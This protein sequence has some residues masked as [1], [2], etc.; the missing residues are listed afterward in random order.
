MRGLCVPKT[1]STSCDQAIFID[2]ATDA[3]VTSDAVLLKIDRFGQWCQQRGAVQRPV[4]PVV[5]LV[6][7]QDALEMVLVPDESRPTP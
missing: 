7:A 2:Q 3:S 4:R 1:W 6:L 5:D